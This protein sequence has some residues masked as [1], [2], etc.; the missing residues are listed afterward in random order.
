MKMMIPHSDNPSI[1][2]P[3]SSIHIF[4]FS[5]FNTSFIFFRKL[6][7]KLVFWGKSQ[8]LIDPRN[9]NK[10]ILRTLSDTS[11]FLEENGVFKI[12]I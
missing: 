11:D 9:P 3:M 4:L 6:I 10:A 12:K 1:N 2:F 8:R 5:S 7:K